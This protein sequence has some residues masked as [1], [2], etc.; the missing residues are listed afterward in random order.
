MP[1][2]EKM[3]YVQKL[4]LLSSRPIVISEDN[5]T[6]SAVRRLVYDSGDLIDDL[7]L[8]C[9][10]DITTKNIHRFEKYHKNFEIVKKKIKEVEQKD[11]IRKFQPPVSGEEIMEYFGLNPCKEIGDIKEAIKEAILE[12]IIANEHKPAFDFMV[13]KGKEMGLGN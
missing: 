3:K 5:V 7:I 1:L 10:A 11:K 6:D 2:N 13:K 12:G 4:V 9:K 8:L